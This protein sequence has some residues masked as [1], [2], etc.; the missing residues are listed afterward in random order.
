MRGSHIGIGILASD[1]GLVCSTE[2]LTQQHVTIGT[3]RCYLMGH[4]LVI[5]NKLAKILCLGSP[6]RAT[7]FQRSQN[8]SRAN[9]FFG[10]PEHLMDN[11]ISQRW[12]QKYNVCRLAPNL[13]V[14]I[15]RFRSDSWLRPWLK[16]QD[17]TCDR[18]MRAH[19]TICVKRSLGYSGAQPSF[20]QQRLSQV[21]ANW[22]SNLL[23]YIVLPRFH[24]ET[25]FLLKTIAS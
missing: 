11:L 21:M 9:D 6:P 10:T 18:D 24:G 14:T 23:W 17:S 16:T 1:I 5:F 12:W 4:Q 3:Q 20:V 25:K 8:N 13:H 2:R 22:W 19:Q 15:T 7:I